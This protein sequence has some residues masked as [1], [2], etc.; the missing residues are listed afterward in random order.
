MGS[1][2]LNKL[3]SPDAPAFDLLRVPVIGRFFHW[4]HA[5]TVLQIPLLLVSVAMILHGREGRLSAAS[6]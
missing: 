1:G 6:A 5:R 2:A 3:L 4:R